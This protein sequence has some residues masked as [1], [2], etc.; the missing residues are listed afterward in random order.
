[1]DILVY[2]DW[3]GQKG[4]AL[5]GTLSVAHTRGGEIFSFAYNKAWLDAGLAQTLDPDL[6]LFT[7]TQYL[8]AGKKNFGIFL[9]SSPDRWGC[10]LMMRREAI[11][12]RMESRMPKVLFEED[13]LPSVF[14]A[15]RM[16]ALRFKKETTGPFLHDN[17]S[18]ASPP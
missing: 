3:I 5:M 15:H 18:L 9:D 12:A 1:M 4:P 14:D 10:V 17:A 11:A 6:Q 2:A 13:Y 7:G 8:S 16:G